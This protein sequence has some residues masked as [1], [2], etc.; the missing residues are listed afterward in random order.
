M[1]MH[2]A[3]RY[4]AQ[5][6]GITLSQEQAAMACRRVEEAG[7]SNKVEIRLQDYRDLRGEQFDAI[8]SIGMFE[9]VGSIR[10][11]EYLNILWGLLAEGTPSQP[12][13]FDTWRYQDWPSQLH[14]SL[15]LP[16][17]RVDGCRPGDLG[18][19]EDGLRGA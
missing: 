6:V 13:N 18:H 15:C 19:G 9:H 16:R 14:W 8:S 5:V 7:L 17:R 12:R 1:A 11:G 10:A 4:G 3:S 2:A